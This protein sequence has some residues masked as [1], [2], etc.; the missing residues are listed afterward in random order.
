MVESNGLSFGRDRSMRLRFF[1]ALDCGSAK[2]GLDA[3]QVSTVARGAGST[4]TRR[5]GGAIFAFAI[6]GTASGSEKQHDTVNLVA[7]ITKCVSWGKTSGVLFQQTKLEYPNAGKM[8][9]AE[10]RGTPVDFLT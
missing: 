2:T 4:C 1:G 5:V 8:R 6:S 3:V 10:H 9:L 7:C